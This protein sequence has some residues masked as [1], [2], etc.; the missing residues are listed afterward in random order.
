MSWNLFYLVNK[1]IICQK[2]KNYCTHKLAKATAI[3]NLLAF[4]PPNVWKSYYNIHRAFYSNGYI[5]VQQMYI[6]I[7][8]IIPNVLAD[9]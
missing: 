7:Q 1:Y 5:R 2:Q 6:F 8:I 4:I 3:G 9:A